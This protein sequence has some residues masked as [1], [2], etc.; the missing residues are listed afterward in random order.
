MIEEQRRKQDAK[1]GSNEDRPIQNSLPFMATVLSEEVGE[2]AREII[3]GINK[4]GLRE[5]R[6]LAELVDVAAVAVKMA[7]GLNGHNDSR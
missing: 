1:W 7:E 6:L 4:G 3:D 2:V 5:D